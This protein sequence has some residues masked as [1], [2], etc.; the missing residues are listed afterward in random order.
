[1]DNDLYEIINRAD[2]SKKEL[3]ESDLFAFFSWVIFY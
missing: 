1:L 2:L 3:S